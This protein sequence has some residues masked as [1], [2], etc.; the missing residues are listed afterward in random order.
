M[1]LVEEQGLGHDDL[2]IRLFIKEVSRSF[3]G[4]F[5]VLS[6]DSG[7]S[8]FAPLLPFCIFRG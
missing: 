4:L 1:F 7:C 8:W 2:D 3:T 6:E 5:D